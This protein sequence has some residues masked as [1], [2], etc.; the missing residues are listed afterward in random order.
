M[1]DV[2]GIG[3]DFFAWDKWRLGWINDDS[4]DCVSD[5]GITE[6]TLIPLEL[7][8]SDKDIKAV[9]VAV[10]HTSALVAEARVPKG[11]DSDVCAPGVLLY[12][13][14]TSVKSGSGP[15]RV[16]D[17]TL[18]SGG[19]GTDSVYDKKL[20]DQFGIKVVIGTAISL[21]GFIVQFIGL[22]GM[23]WSAS[24]AQLLA[25][26][27]MMA[28]RALVRRGLAKPP[29]CIKLTSGFELDWFATTLGGIDNA[30]W[31]AK[32][33]PDSNSQTGN[34]FR[35]WTIRTGEI[36]QNNDDG[37]KTDQT[38]NADNSGSKANEFGG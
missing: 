32:R 35:E 26:L 25:V 19:C 1:G 23:H 22:R 33:A 8:T 20:V 27:I 16:L 4:V 13:V 31:M 2:S 30:P 38:P 28:L 34:P 11:I 36:A 24:I 37:S 29:Q 3:P 9:V 12:T 18:G 21:C 14:D 7:K 10:N 15:V 5:P 17:V 6:H